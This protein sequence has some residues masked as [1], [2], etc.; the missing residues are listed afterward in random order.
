MNGTLSNAKRQV[1]LSVAERLDK[2][3]VVNGEC[4]ETRLDL[5]HKY[6]Q[7]KIDGRKIMVHRLS[8]IEFR[9][10][11]PKGIHVLHECDNP[12]CHR[13]SHLFLGTAQDNMKDMVAKGRHRAGPKLEVDEKFIINLGSV[14]SQMEVAEC[15]GVSQTIVSKVLRAHGASRGKTTSFGKGHGR[16]GRK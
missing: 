11:I 4:W 12:R 1:G 8:F 3:R 16:G 10:P 15:L 5:N 13:P 7:I 2:H 14:L 6:P 9:G